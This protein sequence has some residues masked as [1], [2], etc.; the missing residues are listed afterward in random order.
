MNTLKVGFPFTV[1]YFHGLLTYA[2]IIPLSG[3]LLGI[4]GG[5][6]YNSMLWVFRT[7]IVYAVAAISYDLFR[8]EPLADVSINKTLVVL[9]CLV[10]IVN[11][12][13]ISKQRDIELDVLR[14]VFVTTRSAIPFGVH[15]EHPGFTVL[16]I[17]SSR[18]PRLTATSTPGARR[19]EQ[20]LRATP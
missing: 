13:F 1:P 8:L 10:W 18:S 15:L 19:D 7:T 20:P 2:F 14:V 5:G 9:W 6:L 3:F 12:L 4:F 16:I 11:V 17:R